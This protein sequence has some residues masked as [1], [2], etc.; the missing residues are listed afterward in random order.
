MWPWQTL[1]AINLKICRCSSWRSWNPKRSQNIQNDLKT[2]PWFSLVGIES[3]GNE[4][5][6]LIKSMGRKVMEVT[7]ENLQKHSIAIQRGNA[8]CVLGKVSHP[9]GKEEIFE[10]VKH[11]LIVHWNHYRQINCYYKKIRANHWT[12]VCPLLRQKLFGYDCKKKIMIVEWHYSKRNECHGKFL[13]FFVLV[14]FARFS[15]CQPLQNKDRIKWKS[16][17]V[18]S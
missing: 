4:G 16:L 9:E 2:T 10:F 17:K 13:R 8:S 3:W 14:T 6:K 15:I 5:L 7:G 12:C 1:Y 18:Y 11:H